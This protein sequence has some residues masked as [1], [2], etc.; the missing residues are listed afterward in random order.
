MS[1]MTCFSSFGDVLVLVPHLLDGEGDHLEA[2]L[3]HV[4]RAGRAHAVAHHLRLLHDL[5]DSE[6]AD[7]AA[8]MAFHDKAY[9]AF[10]LVGQFREELF[11]CGKDGL[12]VR[13]DFDLG[14][15]FDGYGDTLFGIEIL[16]RGDVEAHEFERE[17][18]RVFNNRED[19]GAATLDDARA[20]ETVDDDGLIRAGFAKHLGHEGGE[21][22]GGENYQTNN[23]D[24]RVRHIVPLS[25]TD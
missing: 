17:L 12:L 20:T 14:D 8:Q 2:H 9:E 18:A 11:G 1:R 19:D 3:V 22:E 7:D 21:E 5:L 4:V 10:A 13:A 15:G 6:L 25:E 24:Y 16:L 23:D